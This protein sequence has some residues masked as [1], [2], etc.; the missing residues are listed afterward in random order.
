MKQNIAQLA[1]IMGAAA[2]AAGCVSN[3]ARNPNEPQRETGIYPADC[4]QI[5]G[6]V[7]SIASR[8]MGADGTIIQFDV[9]KN[10]VFNGKAFKTPDKAFPTLSTCYEA[11]VPACQGFGSDK[12]QESLCAAQ[13][14]S[15][16]NIIPKQAG[17][18]EKHYAKQQNVSPKDVFTNVQ[19]VEPLLRV[20][21]NASS[22]SNG[23]SLLN[24]AA[25]ALN[26]Q[27]EGT[28]NGAR[29]TANGAATQAGQS[30]ADKLIG[31]LK[32]YIPG[33]K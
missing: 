13:V 4:S 24:R 20:L 15:V 10:T 1:V 19:G 27:V 9:A 21:E 5:P 29:R 28:A 16:S 2:A 31:T 12:A 17:I 26:R 23:N 25:E 6:A 7:S 18:L 22:E 30:T 32:G 14:E 33:L 11:V 3:P 8:V